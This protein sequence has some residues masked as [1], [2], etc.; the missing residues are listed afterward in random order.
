MSAQTYKSGRFLH[1]MTGLTFL[2]TKSVKGKKCL[3]E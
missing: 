3:E 1:A 2:L